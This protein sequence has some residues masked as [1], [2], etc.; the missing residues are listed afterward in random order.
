MT[1]PLA[2]WAAGPLHLAL[3]GATRRRPWSPASLDAFRASHRQAMDPRRS[4]Q[5]PTGRAVA[6]IAYGIH[7]DELSS[8][9]AA[10][11]VAYWLVSGQDERA[12][13][14]RSELL[15]L[16]DPCENP[17]GRE[18][19][20]A[21]LRSF[22]HKVPNPDLE[23][24]SHT[25]AWPWGRGNHF[26]FDLNRDWFSMVH[27]ESKRSVEIAGWIPQLVVDS[28]E[29][30]SSD[31]YLFPPA[32][33]PF[34]PLQP[35]HNH[36][37]LERFS[38]DQ[39]RAL[40]ERG[41][42][43]YTREWNEEF[44]P[45][46]GSSWATYLGAIGV[47]YEMSGTEGTWVR[48][49]T[50]ETRTYPQAVE[51][52]TTSSV[53]NLTSLLES[54]DAILADAWGSRKAAID[55]ASKGHAA[56]ILPAERHPDRAEALVRTLTRQG[57]EVRRLETPSSERW[58]VVDARTGASES[59]RLPAGSF[60]VPL[61]QP[62]GWLARVLL[63]PHV[64]MDAS[65]LRE[66]REW[67]E[68]GKGSRLYDTTAWSLALGHGVEAWW[69]EKNASS[70]GAPWDGS[71]EA[72]AARESVPAP[73][74][75][76][77]QAYAFSGGTE[78]SSSA[79][80]ALLQAGAHVRI[81]G[82]P[83]SVG[84]RSWSRGTLVVPREGNAGT[85][86]ELLNTIA[87]RSGIEPVA[88]GTARAEDGPDL[89]G[90]HF[91]KLQTPRVG[92]FA[93]MPVSPSEYGAV[94]HLLDET[95]GMRF[96]ALDVARF[97]Q[98]DLSRYN[99]LV[100]PNA[101]GSYRGV[102]G[103]AGV[104][105]LE[106]WVEAG[107]TAIGLGG[108][109][110]FLADEGIEL[111]KARLRS[112]ALDTY[113][114]VVWSLPAAAAEAAGR[115]RAV[116]ETAPPDVEDGD[117]ATLA[118]TRSNPYDVAPIIGA[119]ARPFVG[120]TPQ[121]TPISGK[122]VSLEAWTKPWVASGDEPDEALLE[123]ADRRLRLFAPQGAFLRADVDGEHWLTWGVPGDTLDALTRSS[124]ALVAEP[125]VEVPV[126]YADLDRLHLGGLL[127]PE[128]AARIA[129]TAY[130]T[131]ESRGRGQVLLFLEGPNFRSWTWGTR[132]LLTNA[133]L[134]GPGL[135]TRWSTPW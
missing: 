48:K 129:K 1:S 56:W 109:A 41:Y 42:P 17:D 31:S 66:Q 96:N 102:V 134:Y 67:L 14:M 49:R 50:G 115:F 78:A 46:Y 11:A 2:S 118:P 44:F 94:W 16:I 51:H 117:A 76:A 80:A 131:R 82:E 104:A 114:P 64:P 60:V 21:M 74:R 54:K 28:H 124:D 110:R 101:F 70:A 5:P 77:V 62:S 63:D 30:G 23:D 73:S 59:T 105:A 107:G 108:G 85:V 69:T 9:D 86:H 43:Y 10:A 37:W 12:V 68:R 112:Q 133:V 34:N 40:D 121:G 122:P 113:P 18:R 4:K 89:G 79:L 103:D 35:A 120:E 33:A 58:T 83:F 135:G 92:V 55:A 95:L 19:F 27:P 128:A 13:R 116:G 126:R 45:G 99:V 130:V 47:L 88:I 53:A 7:G 15:V 72:D 71:A 29:M 25:G 38:Q 26:L 36:R 91:F 90:R 119:G 39:A 57:I 97:G 20:L 65:F 127:W 3:R 61:D 123:R 132:R 8:V 87:G 100:F 106:E 125:P 111:T 32:R 52:H 81:A 75:G 98:L 93:G 22:G 24:L 84:G 6:W